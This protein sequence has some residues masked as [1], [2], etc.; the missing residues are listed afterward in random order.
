MGQLILDDLDDR[1]IEC[2]E[3]RA[4]RSGRSV[5]AEHRAILEQALLQDLELFAEAAA[6]LRSLSPKLKTDSA[7]LI[8][9]DRDRDHATADR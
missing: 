3:R 9:Q 6:R 8:R 4:A 2:L 5:E 7:D 1:L